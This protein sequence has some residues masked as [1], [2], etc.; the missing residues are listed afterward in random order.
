MKYLA[1][2]AAFAAITLVGCETTFDVEDNF[3]LEE[4]PAYIA[5]DADG[6]NAFREMIGISEGASQEVFV[7]SPTTDLSGA[8]VSY[9]I[10][11]SAVFGEDYTI[12]G[13]SPSGGTI[14][15]RSSGDVTVRVRGGINIVAIDDGTADGDK[16]LVLTLTDATDAD[17]GDVAIGRGGQDFLRTAEFTIVDIQCPTELAGDYNAVAVYTSH[18]LLDSAMVDT[19]MS[20]VTLASTSEFAYS[21]SDLSGGLYASDGEYGVNF[22]TDGLSGVIIDDCGSISLDGELTDFSGQMMA[23]TGS[24]TDGVV[25]L[26]LAGADNGESWVLTLTP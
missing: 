24:S 19:I 25:T 6:D 20:T 13:A 16:S 1:Y 8:T 3:D 15:I 12:D 14:S 2:I 7:E 9:S 23:L 4:L 11:G 26:E 21:V 5:F 10:S 18:R 17:G 22:G